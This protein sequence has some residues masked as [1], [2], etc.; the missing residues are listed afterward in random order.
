MK[1][2]TMKIECE[3]NERAGFAIINVAD[4]DAETMTEYSDS[5][6]KPIT[7]SDIA[8]MSKPDL[9]EMLEAHGVDDT[10]GKSPELKKRL[11]AVMFID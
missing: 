10:S 6:A 5:P 11:E 7:R 3:A 8:R 2:K 4:F 9:I 1:L